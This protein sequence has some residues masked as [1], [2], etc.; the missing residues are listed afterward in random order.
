MSVAVIVED[1]STSADLIARQLQS[2]GFNKT[3]IS[4]TAEGGINLIEETNPHLVVIDERLPDAS[5]TELIRMVRDQLPDVAIV[6]CTV[7]DDAG[8]MEAAF[9]AGCNYYAVKPNGLRQLCSNRGSVQD[10]LDIQ[11]QEVYR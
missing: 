6:M 4:E 9:E 3:H 11:A 1:N 8:L 2:V 7:V 5:G 10:L